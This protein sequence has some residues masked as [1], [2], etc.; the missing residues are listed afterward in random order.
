[1]RSDSITVHSA[2]TPNA[3][4]IGLPG[5]V[6]AAVSSAKSAVKPADITMSADHASSPNSRIQ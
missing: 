1:L 2:A 6:T 3:D 5:R 4:T